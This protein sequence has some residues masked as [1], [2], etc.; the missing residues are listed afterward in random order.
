MPVTPYVPSRMTKNGTQA[1]PS[2]TWTDLTPNSAV[3]DA[4]Y[5]TTLDGTSLSIVVPANSS[6]SLMTASASWTASTA[7]R[8]HN[9]RIMRVSDSAIIA[10]GVALSGATGTVSVTTTTPVTVS[11]TEAYKVQIWGSSTSSGTASSGTNTLTLTAGAISGAPDF[12]VAGAGSSVTSSGGPLTW[13]HTMGGTGINSVVFVAMSVWKS[14]TGFASYTRTVK[15][16]STGANQTMASLGAGNWGGINNRWSELFYLLNP[17]PGTVTMSAQ[18]T[19]TVPTSF[20]ASSVSYLNVSAVGTAVI[21]LPGGTATPTTGP[22][23]SAV[24]HRVIAQLGA[25]TP[26]A[27]PGISAPTGNQRFR[28]NTQADAPLMIQDLFGAATVTLSATVPNTTETGSIAV[29]LV[30]VTDV[31][32]SINDQLSIAVRR[33]GFY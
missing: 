21:N 9:I 28:D 30:P 19:T 31:P 24:N 29:D 18:L 16:D 5:T 33:A 23:A 22:V 13:T 25:W 15:Y 26:S 2:T 6:E 11:T 3:N 32:P 4:T 7:A 10:T 14:A 1:W 17:A 8:T 12:D 27:S 20:T